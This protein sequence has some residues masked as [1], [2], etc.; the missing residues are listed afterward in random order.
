MTMVNKNNTELLKILNK[1]PDQ[2]PNPVMQFSGDGILLYSNQASEA[3][4]KAWDINIGDKGVV[5]IIDK[6]I[7]VKND[8]TEQNFEISIIKNER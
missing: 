7:S 4:I 8:Q 1:F 3:I 2:N 6:L 5:D